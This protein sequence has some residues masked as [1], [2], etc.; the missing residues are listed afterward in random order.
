[1]QWCSALCFLVAAVGAATTESPSEPSPTLEGLNPSQ[2]EKIMIE[3]I[4]AKPKGNSK[5]AFD[6]VETVKPIL[7][8]FKKQML[9]D[10]RKMQQELDSDVAVIKKC[11][12]KMEKDAL[13]VALLEDGNQKKK[14]CPSKTAVKK[15]VE[16]ME[17]LDGKKQACKDLEEEN[18]VD[19]KSAMELVKQWNKQKI[20]KK[21]CKIDGGE[22]RYHYVT[23]L[24]NHFENKLRSF[25]KKLED[26]LKKQGFGKKLT[27]NCDAIKHYQRKLKQETCQK[28]KDAFEGCSCRRVVKEQ[29]ARKMLNQ[30]YAAAVTNKENNEKE[31]K[32][33]N[34]AAKLEWRAVG[35][36]ECLI[37]VMSGKKKAD[38]KQ[39]EKCVKGQVSTKPLDLKYHLTPPKAKC[40]FK[41]LDDDIRKMCKKPKKK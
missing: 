41:G 6:F 2:I 23:R 39:L 22:T 13:N 18:K 10:K 21:D 40:S 20:L 1:M 27:D 35:R 24:A 17:P 9:S 12:T 5:Q 16:K 37:T 11:N 36:I 25:E 15:C 34:A 19:H 30:C 4:L 28:L 7:D 3:Q 38:A 14:K 26:L 33:K 29:K 31:I 8:Q 32:K